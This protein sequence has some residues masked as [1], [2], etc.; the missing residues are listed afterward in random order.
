MSDMTAR[1][2]LQVIACV[3]F[4]LFM[5]YFIQRKKYIIAVICAIAF[6]NYV[7]INLRMG[8]IYES[9]ASPSPS[10]QPPVVQT[11]YIPR[12]VDWSCTTPLL[13]LTILMKSNIKDPAVYVL[14]LFMD[15]LMVYTG[16]LASVADTDQKRYYLFTASM[17]FYLLLFYELFRYCYKAHPGLCLFLLIAWMIYPLVWILHRTP[18]TS[19]AIDN[20]T[21]DGIIAVI[22]VFSKIGYGF[23]LPV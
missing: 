1:N 13:V 5:F 23:L 2:D 22:D 16:Y 6:A 14:I 19:P 15:I 4:F 21:Y 11:D 9:I 3:M 8:V 7:A 12:Y 20:Y 10:T 17:V 18:T